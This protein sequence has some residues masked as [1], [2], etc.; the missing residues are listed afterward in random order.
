VPS[1][2]PLRNEIGR[3]FPDRPFAIEFWDGTQLPSTNGGGPTFKLQ[4][5]KAIGHALRAPG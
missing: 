1:P 5:R 4:S 2:A 3:V